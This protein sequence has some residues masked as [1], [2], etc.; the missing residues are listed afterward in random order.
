MPV[1]LGESSRFFSGCDY[2]PVEFYRGMCFSVT[3]PKV[4][5]QDLRDW[6]REEIGKEEDK[7]IIKRICFLL[8]S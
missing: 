5:K 4:L 6:G 8:F 3:A 7:K 2:M 1:F